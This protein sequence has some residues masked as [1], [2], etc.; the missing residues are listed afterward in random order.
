MYVRTRPRD[1]GLL[2]GDGTATNAAAAYNQAG[3]DY[4]AYADGDPEHLFSFDGLHA[5]A[6][7]RLWSLLETKLN[8]LRATGVTSISVLDIGCGPG[9]WLRRVVTHARLLGFSN[10]TARGFDVA[11]AQIQTAQRMAR[12]V[13][14]LPGVNLSFDV[15]DMT[16]P[17]PEAN[18]S[19]DITLCLYSVLSHLPV[20]SLPKVSREIARVTRGHFITT[21]RSIGSTPTIFVDSIE[22][23]RYFKLDH[24]QDRCQVELCSGRRIAVRFHL[25]TVEELRNCFT[26]HFDID[27]LLGLD[28]FHN[29]FIP[30]H[31]WNPASMS[32]DPELTGRLAELE[33]TYARTPSFMDRAT[34]LLLVG[35][36]DAPQPTKKNVQPS[37]AAAPSHRL[38]SSPPTGASLDHKFRKAA[39]AARR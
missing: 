10:I 13:A 11:Q 31:R 4:V 36:R 38:S 1:L 17:L 21:V 8:N 34:H 23:A 32:V 33:E 9:T 14:G 12:D 16:R 24:D 19:V 15:A 28:I 22:K 18:A 29:R 5:Y 20:T 37:E 7:R 3:D 6:D 2:P 26:Q 30:D 39:A 27:D 35:R 25:F